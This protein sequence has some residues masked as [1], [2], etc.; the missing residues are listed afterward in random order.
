MTMQRGTFARHVGVG[1][2]IMTLAA[3]LLA[4]L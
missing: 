3:L 2:G 1:V 4:L